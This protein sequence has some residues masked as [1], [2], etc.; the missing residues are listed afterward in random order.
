MKPKPDRY[1]SFAE[2]AAHEREAQDYQIRWHTRPSPYL[3]LAPHGGKIEPGTSEIA[4]AIAAEHFS[5]YALEGIKRS[6]NSDLHITCTHFDEPECLR[7]LQTHTAIS[8]HGLADLKED[9]VSIGGLN[10]ELKLRL[11]EA[12]QGA[13]FDVRPATDSAWSGAS[14][15]NLCNRIRPGVQMEITRALRERLKEGS[16]DLDEFSLAV[17]SCLLAL[18]VTASTPSIVDR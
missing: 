2:L 3:I 1:G 7:L 13:E 18:R 12:L 6:H 16:S 17:R 14:P 5:F 9:Y 4:E 8:I 10:E 11:L 15:E